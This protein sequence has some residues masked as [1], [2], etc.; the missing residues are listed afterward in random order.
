MAPEY[1]P[2]IL[3]NQPNMLATSSSMTA[4][5]LLPSVASTQT[6][7]IPV[8]FHQLMKPKKSVTNQVSSNLGEKVVGDVLVAVGVSLGITPFI[9]VVD[10]AIV[11]RAAG[12]HTILSSS[13]ESLLTI[14]RN[15]VAFVKSPMFFMMWGVYA[16]TYATANSLKTIVEHEEYH[17]QSTEEALQHTR[18]SSAQR[19]AREN[20]TYG[21]MGIF[22][23]TTVVNSGTSLLKDRAYAKMFGTTGAA[24]SFPLITYGLWATRDLMVVGSS[25]ILPEIVG[26]QLEAHTSLEKADALRI[27]QLT[28]PIATQFLAGPCQLLGLDFYNRPLANMSHAEA[29]IERTRFLARG[30][31]SIVA[32]RV[33]R[34]FPAYSIGGVYNTKF[35]DMW[36]DRLIQ[37]EIRHLHNSDDA[38]HQKERASRLV[39]LVRERHIADKT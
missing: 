27:S 21:K 12:S 17:R 26:K 22:L 31:S 9:T 14:A 35:R 30:F 1:K 6:I 13:R 28:V 36:R 39:G 38:I 2:L 5:L 33:A 18:P 4:P 23:G 29:A 32:A 7:R 15:P 24:T 8:D 25:F 34:I 16:S 10:K 19:S 11:Q 3:P 20:N 37:K